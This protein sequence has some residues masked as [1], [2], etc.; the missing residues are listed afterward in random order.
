MIRWLLVLAMVGV[1]APAWA[2]P[3]YAVRSAKPCDTCH[4][5]PTNWENPE[6]SKRKCSL[7][8]S[9]CHVNP[10]G[11]GM[12]NEAG[13]FYGRQ[14]LPMWGTRP[15]DRA[16]R[17]PAL[18]ASMPSTAPSSQPTGAT[19]TQPASETQP[20]GTEVAP[21][22]HTVPEPGTAGRYAGIEPHPT[23]QVGADLRMM[24]YFPRA[25][26]EENAFFPMQTDLYLAVR[27]YNPEK[28]N[29]GR[30]TLLVNAGFL[31]SRGQKF[32]NF[33]D[34]YFVREA[35]A[36]YHDLPYNSYVRVGRFLPPYGWKL[37][38]HS[39]FIR[40]GQNFMGQPFD[41]EREVTGVEVGVNPNYPYLH[42]ALFNATDDW[43]KPV[44]GDDGYGAALSAGWRDL[45]WQLGT[46]LMYGHRD[47]SDQKFDQMMAGLQWAL[48]FDQI[49]WGPFIYLGEYDV[50]HVAF[51]GRDAVTSLTAFHEVDWI[52]VE[53]LNAL[54]RY[55]WQD[56]DIKLAYDTRHRA[57]V[58]L[59]W[60][61]V[62]YLSLSAQYR[63]NWTNTSD[64][65]ETG[66]DE[67]LA[68]I[69][70]WY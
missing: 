65:F 49:G 64:R 38:D 25:K 33:T 28:L 30:L 66:T 21:A 58:G 20:A 15:A 56:P 51:E 44:K 23:F 17:T 7:D 53:S 5:D 59:D 48:N 19:D 24:G 4:V 39:A 41:M 9:V 68:I 70:G 69:H 37:D 8:C 55:D 35:W 62:E 63:H 11:G 40:Q 14:T 52:F 54:V 32:D 61:P 10:T 27:P 2:L 43:K 34:R 67:I 47:R 22:D 42:L 60:H 26:G 13:L 31:G 12:R 50:N 1:A 18:A 3:Q 46:S 45:A 36:M 16:Y 29:E 6:M 57:T